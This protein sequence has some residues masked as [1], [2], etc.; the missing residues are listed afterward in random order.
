MFPKFDYFSGRPLASLRQE[1]LRSEQPTLLFISPG[2]P[3][4][5]REASL[6]TD[7]SEGGTTPAMA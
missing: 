1:D 6:A 5:P 3:E 7:I 4:A 2:E